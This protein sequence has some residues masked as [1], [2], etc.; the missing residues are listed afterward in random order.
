MVTYKR[1][2]GTNSRKRKSGNR[3]LNRR[4]KQR[5]YSK[6]KR[7]VGGAKR[8][9]PS[10]EGLS[11]RVRASQSPA[12]APPTPA[13]ASPTPARA[14]APPPPARAR[15][16]AR[17]TIGKLAPKTI[18]PSP[19]PNE[20]YEILKS[21][22]GKLALLNDAPNS[23]LI[24]PHPQHGKLKPPD[25]DQS[26]DSSMYVPASRYFE[27]AK[28][29][30]FLIHDGEKYFNNVPVIATGEGMVGYD[31]MPGIAFSNAIKTNNYIELAEAEDKFVK[32]KVEMD[33]QDSS[34]TNGDYY[35]LK[36][37]PGIKFEHEGK[38]NIRGADIYISEGFF[39]STKPN[40]SP[41]VNII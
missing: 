4:K 29:N 24:I 28:K 14:R 11:K 5:K 1:K 20:E 9:M 13:R 21:L 10:A 27:N 7:F 6:S 16:S 38:Y 31:E 33:P 34:W 30:F 18:V 23:Y 25:A 39:K 15:A 35:F 8:S 19:L 40:P 3:Y 41:S 17:S 32:K 37:D 26:G 2:R 22:Y 36:H 12:R